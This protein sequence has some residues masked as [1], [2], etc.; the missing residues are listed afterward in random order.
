MPRNVPKN[1]NE[2][3]RW[4][5]KIYYHGQD[6]FD[7]KEEAKKF[8]KWCRR[9][10]VWARVVVL[11]ESRQWHGA[12]ARYIVYVPKDRTIREASLYSNIRQAFEENGK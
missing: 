6:E 11:P 12:L 9:D 7:T 3:G 1:T 5:G 2:L 10:G 4:F 8:A